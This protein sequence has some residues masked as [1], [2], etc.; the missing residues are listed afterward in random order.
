LL[1]QL[2]PLILFIFSLTACGG[3]KEMPALQISGIRTTIRRILIS[4]LAFDGANVAL[5]GIAHDIKEEKTD[6]GL[7]IIVFK[8]TDLGGNFINIS[9]PSSWVVME[10]DYMVV[11]GIYR[12][13]KN[14]IE[15]QHIEV[16]VLEDDEEDL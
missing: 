10:D 7:P 6:E 2:P 12:R 8:L 1:K 16:I 13:T 9:M 3:E 4:P 14:E 5:E 15:A 11:G